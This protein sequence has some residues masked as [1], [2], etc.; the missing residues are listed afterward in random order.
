VSEKLVADLCDLLSQPRIP[1]N[2]RLLGGS[3]EPVRPRETVAPDEPAMMRRHH[4]AVAITEEQH[5][6]IPFSAPTAAAIC[7]HPL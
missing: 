3:N 1:W 2:G 7:G 5:L 4:T 6:A